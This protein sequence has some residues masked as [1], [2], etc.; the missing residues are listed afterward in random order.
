MSAQF[1]ISQFAGI[2]YFTSQNGSFV[3]GSWQQN[4]VIQHGILVTF[5][6]ENIF[7]RV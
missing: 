7:A 2:Q 3:V 1:H 5:R 4:K 6:S